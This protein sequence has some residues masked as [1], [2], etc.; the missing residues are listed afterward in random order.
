MDA[1]AVLW[2]YTCKDHGEP[3]IEASGVL[4]PNRHPLVPELGA[5]VWLT[6]IDDALVARFALGLA[7]VDLTCDRAEIRY[8]VFAAEVS[9]LRYWPD[10]RAVCDP[11]AVYKLER[12]AWPSRWFLALGPITLG[13]VA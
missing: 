3:G 5:V 12:G 10:V 13:A 8:P 11:T 9:S 2:H 1:P 7:A 6:D 4:R